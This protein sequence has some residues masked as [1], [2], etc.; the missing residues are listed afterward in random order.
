[1]Q[2]L[3][4]RRAICNGYKVSSITPFSSTINTNNKVEFGVDL[5]VGIS[6][7]T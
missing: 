4:K 1:M 2:D 5:G 7:L 6:F 3:S